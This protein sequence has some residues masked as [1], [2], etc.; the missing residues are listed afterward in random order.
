M[1]TE[2][3]DVYRVLNYTNTNNPGL[4]AGATT[5]TA[6]DVGKLIHGSGY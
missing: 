3:F 1:Q 2:A 4:C 5:E 6:N